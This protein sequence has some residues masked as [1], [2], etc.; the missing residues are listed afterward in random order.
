[1]KKNTISNLDVFLYEELVGT[2]TRLPD[3]SNIFTFD[4]AYTHNQTRPT[5]SL[6]FKGESGS[7]R[8]AVKPSKVKLP[9]F[10]SNLLP[11]GHLRQY[12]AEQEGIKPERE[13]FLLSLLGNDLPGAITV[14]ESQVQQHDLG[15]MIQ[16]QEAKDDKNE[17]P[18][19]RFSLAGVQLKFSAI[20]E[21]NGGLTIPV[22]G[23]GGHWI[24]KLP[25]FN[26]EDVTENEYSMVRLAK[27]A[28]LN[29]P[30][31]KLIETESI[32]GLPKDILQFE[33][34]SK[35]L[36][37]KRFDRAED[38]QKIHMEDMAQVFGKYPN[39][40]YEGVSSEN[41]AKLLWLESD[42]ESVLEYIRLL[43]FNI[44]IGN[45]DAHLKNWSIIYPDKH[46]PKLSPAYDLVATIAYNYEPH[47]ALSIAKSKDMTQM[48][49]ESF[50]Q[51]AKKADLPVK[52]VTQTVQAMI[53]RFEEVWR[54]ASDDLPMSHTARERINEHLKNVPL[55]KPLAT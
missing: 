31:V 32:Q 43:V 34:P 40:K 22:N 13:F 53:E 12:L 7:L 3:D 23:M 16:L 45:G 17:K 4:N 38:A 39:D 33:K 21:R 14:R 5:L 19:L 15:L 26:L 47:L 27:M 51:F 1:M 50:E 18:A 25:S 48:S 42:E 54:N 28:G 46:R 44:A 37:V 20:Q 10:F 36:A 41:I 52:L 55:F 35:T 6:S 9:P 24:V 11:E 29:I 2:I 49:M 30:E 8:R